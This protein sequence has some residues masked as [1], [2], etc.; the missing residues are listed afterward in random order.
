M[1]VLVLPTPLQITTTPAELRE[2]ADKMEAAY[3]NAKLGQSTLV[4]E[5]LGTRAT[6]QW[7]FDQEKMGQAA[8]VGM[9]PH[10]FQPGDIM[11]HHGRAYEVERVVYSGKE[12]GYWVA[13]KGEKD[14]IFCGKNAE[15]KVKREHVPPVS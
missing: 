11:Q 15:Y 7:H 1:D 12:Q 5:W 10:L 13:V 14:P 2:L 4:C 8:F 9:Q 3:K 6:L